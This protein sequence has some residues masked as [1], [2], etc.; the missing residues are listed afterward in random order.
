MQ[1]RAYLLGR[2]GGP[3]VEQLLRISTLLGYPKDLNVVLGKDHLRDRSHGGHMV[4]CRVN[5]HMAVTC[6]MEGLMVT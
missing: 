6:Q 2:L 4:A 3:V 1:S 5:G